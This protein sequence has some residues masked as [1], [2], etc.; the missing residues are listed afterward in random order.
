ME[1][2][3]A[4]I[5]RHEDYLKK[6][7]GS[8]PNVFGSPSAP[9]AGMTSGDIWVITG[10]PK[11]QYREFLKGTWDTVLKGADT[12]YALAIVEAR[13]RIQTLIQGN[14]SS[15]GLQSLLSRG[16]SLAREIASLDSQYSG[17]LLELNE[18][19]NL[20]S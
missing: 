11:F 15:E 16:D 4:T 8:I 7:N 12:S 9:T 6:D 14:D 19:E 2:A 18:C 20:F 3:E 5:E 10:G 13:E 1:A 17:F